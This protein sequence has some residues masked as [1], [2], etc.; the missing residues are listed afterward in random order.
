MRGGG[1]FFF[2]L[3]HHSQTKRTRRD[4]ET[5]NTES[6]SRDAS[7][8]NEVITG[9]IRFDLQFHFRLSSSR[10]TYRNV[11]CESLSTIFLLCA[12]KGVF[13]FQIGGV[14]QLF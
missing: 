9:H 4:Q 7:L 12:R 8:Q 10:G 5:T 13:N 2:T 11:T 1:F 3:Q 14:R 6:G